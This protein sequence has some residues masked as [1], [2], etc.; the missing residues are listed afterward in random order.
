MD[1]WHV[2]RKGRLGMIAMF[3][4]IVKLEARAE[5][6]ALMSYTS[7]L[8]AIALMM[9]GGLNLVS[10]FSQQARVYFSWG[11]FAA[12]RWSG[13]LTETVL[14]LFYGPL[15]NPHLRRIQLDSQLSRFALDKLAV[16]PISME[17]VLFTA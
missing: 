6:S 10:E 7:P 16:V 1:E 12:L 5:P 8:I 11:L 17:S 14:A 4:N 9:V 15:A 3:K 13:S 2:A